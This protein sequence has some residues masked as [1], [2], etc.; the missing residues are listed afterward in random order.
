MYAALSQV[1]AAKLA[2]SDDFYPREA[3]ELKPFLA[4]LGLKADHYCLFTGSI[5]PRKNIETLLD[6]YE[7]LP[8]ALRLAI[9]LVI[10]GFEGW[11]TAGLYQRFERAENAGWLHYL[12]Y[13]KSAVLPYL[14]FI[15]CRRS[16]FPISV[17]I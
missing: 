12:G 7:R 9:P 4:P 11:S 5:E 1:Y 8:L 10:S 2:S 3:D 15:I 14:L 17:A 13:V 6:A 16:Q